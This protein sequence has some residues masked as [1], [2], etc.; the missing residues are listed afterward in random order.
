MTTFAPP[1]GLQS[2]PLLPADADAWAA[3]LAVVEESDRT[4]AIQD[5]TDCAEVL[6]DPSV[7]FAADSLAV[8]EGGRLVA[9]LLLRLRTGT[10]VHAVYADGVVHPA[11]RGRGLGAA[12]VAF[13]R[14]RA[15]ELGR[16]LYVPVPECVPAAVALAESSGLV[17]ARYRSELVR[18]LT[19]PIPAVAV[20]DGLQ[21][22][23]LGPGY[24]VTRWDETLRV[25]CETAYRDH[26]GSTPISPERWAYRH[27][28]HRSFRPACSVAATTSEGV[29]AGLVL[30]HEHEAGTVATGRRDLSV[31]TVGTL[32]AWRGRGLASAM[33]ARVLGRAQAQGYLSSSLTVDIANVTGALGGYEL[34]GY[35]MHR[36]TITYAA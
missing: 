34:A 22:H 5:T 2:R 14:S 27:T 11:H 30:S 33:L 28:G 26:W 6:A 35:T 29:V 20:P 18:D 15:A 7:D 19:L 9:T 12:F 32:P 1:A 17:V 31:G 10:D 3:L 24:D 36:R 23:D 21:L 16:D 8:L 13:A 4:G 25:A